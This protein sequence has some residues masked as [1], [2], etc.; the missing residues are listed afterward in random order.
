VTLDWQGQVA[1]WSGVDFQKKESLLAVTNFFGTSFSSGSSSSFSSGSSFSSDARFLAIGSTHGDISVW[2]LEGRAPRRAF[3]AGERMATPLRFL[4]RGNHLI[5]WTA[6]DNT[7]FE[8][9]LE[10]NR[11]IQSWPAP[12]GFQ[13]QAFGLSPDE[14][15]SIAIRWSA[16]VA[17]RNLAG[18][19]ATNLP[20]EV[21]EGY[22]GDF[23]ADGK[24][25]AV[26]STLGFA[27]VWDTA[28]WREEATLS[29]FLN[30]V[31]SVAFSPDGQRL[32]TG[33]SNPEDTVKLWSADSWQ[34]VLTLE[35]T[36]SIYFATAFSPDGNAVGIL[37]SDGFLRVWR[38]PS[39]AEIDAA[40]RASRQ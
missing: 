36:G 1:R 11:T 26:A 38:A 3:K 4:D 24:R 40:E 32:A 29:G 17:G 39:W 12:G 19:S 35:G 5:C 9:D 14:K 33:G 23:S 16:G 28:T 8:W 22:S 25:L 6:A 7:F 18:H 15:L 27:R 21:M 34:E 30:A 13:N 10:A 37:S 31:L 20:I 2:D